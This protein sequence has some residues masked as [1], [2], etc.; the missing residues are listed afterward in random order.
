MTTR[1]FQADEEHGQ[2]EMTLLVNH[3]HETY[4]C[5]SESQ[6]ALVFGGCDGIISSITVLS[7]LAGVGLSWRFSLLIGIASIV[8]NS[9]YIG[10]A[11]FFSSSAHKVFLQSEKR[12]FIWEFNHFREE[13]LKS[14]VDRFEKRGMGRKDAKGV[15]DKMAQ[16]ES[17][18]V[19]LMMSE[20]LGSQL[21][22]VDDT[23]VLLKDSIIMFISFGIFGAIP[24]MI[25][26]LGMSGVEDDEIYKIT[27]SV[28]LCILFFLGVAKSTFS[29]IYWVYSG[30][31]SLFLGVVCA[32]TAYGVAAGVAGFSSDIDLQ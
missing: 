29:S 4:S 2:N 24:V 23:G 16:Y 20:E 3:E 30:C 8:A 28:S 9:L 15:V 5:L 21:I 18:F 11:E 17:F 10:F 26:L 1:H 22:D 25:Y 14:M 32:G 7:T 13:E 6:K 27:L 12:R 19:R 31:E